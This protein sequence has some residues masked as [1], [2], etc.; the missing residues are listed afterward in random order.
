MRGELDVSRA[1]L[2]AGITAIR[3]QW[4]SS[5]PDRRRRGPPRK[6]FRGLDAMKTIARILALA[7][8]L[9]R[10][11][12]V[13]LPTPGS[14]ARRGSQRLTRRSQ[15]PEVAYYNN[16][17][18]VVWVGYAPG[19]QGDIFY[20]AQHQFRRERFRA[21]QPVRIPLRRHGQRLPQVTAGPEWGSTSAGTP[22]QHGVV[23]LLQHGRRPN[24]GNADDRGFRRRTEDLAADTPLSDSLGRVHVAYYDNGYSEVRFGIVG[25]VRHR[26]TSDGSTWGSRR[27]RHLADHR[28]RRGQRGAAA[29]GG[30][31]QALHR[32]SQHRQ[33]QS[34]GRL[35][36]VIDLMK[37]GTVLR[38]ARRVHDDSDVPGGRGRAVF[39]SAIRAATGPRSREV[40]QRHA[41]SGVADQA[42][43][44]NVAYRNGKPHHGLGL[45][46]LPALISNFG[47]D[48][49][50]G[51]FSSNSGVTLGPSR[52]PAGLGN[53]G[54]TAFT[55]YQKHTAVA[56][57]A[58]RERS[59]LP[60]R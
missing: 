44:A 12:R 23:Q 10:L 51:A 31:G 28:R 2:N 24:F 29:G 9:A 40:P 14:A 53:D 21:G 32:L 7:L 19:L 16:I 27:R 11:R 49:L 8:A 37:T 3:A 57:R 46:R 20:S 59:D 26:M 41:A 35:V 33:R 47:V 13:T 22:K 34:A 30:R 6:R 5:L 55:T 4:H 15:F 17:I 45:L 50:T 58:S 18:H 54:T 1:S 42:K 60:A 43:G 52:R 38:D 36:A 39:R 48:H 56:P 25:M